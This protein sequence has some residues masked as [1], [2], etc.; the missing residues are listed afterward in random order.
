M[1]PTPTS[2]P[3]PEPA[4]TATPAAVAPTGQ[5][6]IVFTSDPAGA[7]VEVNGAQTRILARRRSP[8]LRSYAADSV[9][10]VMFRGDQAVGAT[11]DV[12][13]GVRHEVHCVSG[14]ACRVVQGSTCP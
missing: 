10:V 7:E 9:R 2:T 6:C 11:V 1:G 12:Q 8:P 13:A 4:A 5:G 3:A 14:D